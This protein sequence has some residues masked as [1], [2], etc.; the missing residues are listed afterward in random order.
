MAKRNYKYNNYHKKQISK[1]EVWNVL[2][3]ANSLYT[4]IK[5]FNLSADYYDPLQ[6]NQLLVELNNNPQVPSY[7]SLRNALATYKTNAENLQNY[8]QFMAMWDG[9]YKQVLDYK[10][11]LLAFNIDKV[12]IN[13]SDNSEYS[14]QEYKDD[15]KRV[16]KFFDNFGAKQEFRDV[17]KNML[18][19]DTHFVWLR[20]G[21][22]SFDDEAIE[23]DDISENKRQ[24]YT[25][26]TMPQKYCKI[27]GQFTAKNLKGK[28][29]LWDLNLD[30]FTNSRVNILN[31]DPSITQSF[32]EVKQNT[33]TLQSFVVD[34]QTELN[35][36]NSP[37]QNRYV[38]TKVNKGAW[39]FKY[40][41]SNFNVVPP[42]A[43]LMKS[44]FNDDLIER[45]QKDKDIISANAIILGEMK[46]RDKDNVGNNKN[47]FTIDPKQ[48]GQLMK[49]ARNGINKNIKQIALPLEETKLYQFADNNSNMVKNTYGTNAGLGGH[50]STVIYSTDN[51]SQEQ[52]QIA[53]TIDYHSIADNVYPQFENF[54]NFFVNKKTKKYKFRFKVS[55]STLPFLRQKDIDN[56]TKFMDKGLNIPIERIGSLLG[57]EM[58]EFE[59]MVKEAKYGD[60]QD[61]LF[62]L[63]NT[64]TNSQTTTSNTS[65]DNQGGRPRMETEDLSD[66]GATSREYD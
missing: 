20:D 23:L 51:L 18:L 5:G 59:A 53:S 49:L 26:Q 54:L 36:I 16:K 22:G 47:A 13:V 50:N 34:N 42:F 11:N 37:L 38:R 65:T 1:E 46:T 31:Y 33:R 24:S 17:V 21:Y 66:G 4:Q 63:M 15:C 58:N 39:V 35:R 57:Y 55:G 28:A 14:S 52:A 32:N 64:N 29:F 56:H 7:D 60:M 45:L 3:Y 6:E 48:I 40:N 30:Y 9:I 10:L 12:C 8:S 43:Y 44:V 19:N 62:L 41:T 2:D 61:N 27:T 25:L